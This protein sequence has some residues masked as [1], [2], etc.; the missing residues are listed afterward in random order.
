MLFRSKLPWASTVEVT[1]GVEEA[2]E[3]LRLG[4]PGVQM[5]TTLFRP[6]TYLELAEEH[7]SRTLLVA[8]ALVVVALFG[9]LYHW[10]LALIST[11]AVAL[12]AC[13]AGTVLYLYGMSLNM[14]L[15]AGLVVALG[16]IIDDAI[17]DVQNVA[18]RLQIG[19]AHV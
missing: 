6:A 12:S 4:L 5:D 13:A 15:I 16:A 14:M 3:S 8:F 19:R 2:V 10:R 7:L 18:R 9:M 1:R 17:I 11:L